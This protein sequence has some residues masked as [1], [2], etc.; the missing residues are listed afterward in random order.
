MKRRI[1]L[2]SYALSA[3][4][5][6]E[7]YLKAQKIRTIVRRYFDEAFK[8]F[9]ILASPTMPVLP[10]RIGEKIENPLEI[11]TCDILTVPANLAGVPA[12]SMPCGFVEGLPVGLQLTGPHFR[13]DQ[14]L[15]IGYTFEALQKNTSD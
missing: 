6:D 9:D 14:L 5:Y 3:G 2:G 8:K 15:R 7:Y 1:I 12:I 11:Y 10:F 4:Y 13:E